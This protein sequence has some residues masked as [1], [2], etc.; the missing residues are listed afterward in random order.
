MLFSK[1]RDY[2]IRKQLQR[3]EAFKSA[4]KYAWINFLNKKT[5]EKKCENLLNNTS[6][7]ALN[8]SP[9]SSKTKLVRRCVLNNRAR[10][11]TKPYNISRIKL[12]EMIQFG[13]I[14]G[15]KKSV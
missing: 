9:R 10:G 5:N 11:L 15:Y 4:F 8:L 6:N 13:V 12:R 3:E 14:P 2:R 7:F 1:V